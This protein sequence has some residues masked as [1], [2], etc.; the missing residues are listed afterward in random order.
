MLSDGK[1]MSYAF[2]ILGAVA[3]GGSSINDIAEQIG[4]S[5]SYIAKVIAVLRKAG[6]MNN[7]YELARPLDQISASEVIV[8]ADFGPID[9]PIHK[10]IAELMLG[11][12]NVSVRQVLES[13]D[14]KTT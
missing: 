12:L 6:L 10:Y 7:S 14:I 1:W 5:P 13:N 9:D 11:G 4:G 2:R 8:L 3:R